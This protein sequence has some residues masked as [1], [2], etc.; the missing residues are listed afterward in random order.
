M[1]KIYFQ[2]NLIS[3]V[4]QGSTLIYNSVSSRTQAILD[5]A[6]S[7]GYTLP[8][9]LK[10]FDT[11]IEDLYSSG[12]WAL[13]DLHYIFINNGSDLNF[14]MINII[15]P[16][17]YNGTING[18]ITSDEGGV[19][20]DGKSYINTNFNPSL[21]ATGQKYLQNNAGRGAIVYKKISTDDVNQSNI[22][23]IQGASFNNGMGCGSSSNLWYRI[24]Q[25]STN[26]S[27]GIDLSGTGL[28]SINRLSS[29][30]TLFINKSSNTSDTSTS[31][32]MVNGTQ[33][34]FIRGNLYGI[35]TLS[36]YYMGASITNTIAQSYR[37]AINKYLATLGL[38]QNA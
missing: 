21:L 36:S 4:Y 19:K 13:N 2:N 34:I 27:K 29:V 35:D 37:T 7:K 16:N 11:L 33:S 1:A 8:T 30:S 28:K 5:Y 9:D 23:G 18:G 12:I 26:S 25:G 6:N 24:N 15:N 10:A 20:G 14:R 32:G 17:Q 38:Q 22:D 3:K 31:S